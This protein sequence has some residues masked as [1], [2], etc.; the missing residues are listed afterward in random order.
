MSIVTR[1]QSGLR[2]PKKV[3]RGTLY[4]PSTGHWNGPGIP[5]VPHEKCAGLLRGIQNYHMDVKGWFDIA[6]NYIVC[7][8]GVIFEGR[9]LNVC[10]G[11]NGTN[12]GNNTSHAVMWMAGKGDPFPQDEKNGFRRA[13]RFISD[14]THAPDSAIAH[15]DHKATECP[16]N[17][18]YNWIHAGMPG[19]TLAPSP[20][21]PSGLPVLREGSRGDHVI[22]LQ[23][24]LRNKA[25]QNLVVDG[26]FGP[27]T[28]AAVIN[29]QRFFKLTPTPDGVVGPKTWGVIHYLARH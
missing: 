19:A 17:E 7:Q 27:A 14:Q 26:V 28:K 29:I 9:G 11:A 15:R 18:R 20:A 6:Y 21:L 24:V 22:V 25:G 8:H 16:G 13:V 5:V 1:S 4:R 12:V 2:A 10:N 3:I 23:T